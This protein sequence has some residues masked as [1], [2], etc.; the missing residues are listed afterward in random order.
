MTATAAFPFAAGATQPALDAALERP[1]FD[2][3]LRIGVMLDST[4]VPRWIEKVLRDIA[5]APHLDLSLVVVDASAAAPPR[6]S[7]TWREWLRRQRAAFPYR[8]WEWYL[9]ADYRRFKTEGEDPFATVDATPLLEGAAIDRVAP[10]RTKFVDRFRDEDV[11]RIKQAGLDVMLRFG[12]RI[13]KGGIL[14]VATF[15]VWSLHHDDNRAY[16]GGPALFWEMYERNP[17]SGSVLQVLTEAL[18]G[19]KVI[20]RSLGATNFASLHKNRREAYWKAAEFM[21]RRLTDLWREGW[22]YLESLETFDEPD[23]YARG[24]YR[25]PTNGV[26]VQFLAQTLVHRARMKALQQL[27]DRWVVAYRLRDRKS[28]PIT[29]VEPPRGRFYADPFLGEDRGR[30]FLFI[31]DFVEATG[32]GLISALEIRGDGTHGDVEPVLEREYHLSYPSIFR[33]KREWWM[34]PET[35][36]RRAVELYRAA[37]FPRGWTLERVLLDGVDARDATLVEW[38]GRWWM[39]VTICVAGGPRADELSLFY[40]DTPLGPWRPHP[41]NPIVSDV[42][43]ARSAGALYV[44]RG[45]LVRPAQ[46]CSRGYGYAVTLNRIDRVTER[47]YRETPIAA[48]PPTWH[49]RVRATHTV[50]RTP[51]VEAF[52]GR[53]LRWRLR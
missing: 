18:D 16:R 40:A 28:A 39:F 42:R 47:E 4:T 31:E 17:E 20:Y 27:D 43:R 33:W 32:R 24:I 38:N 2:R 25:R 22:S 6:R 46:N 14:G 10:V 36:D 1:A 12:F 23:T 29:I 37:D 3:P 11:A 50:A 52:D 53:L 45:A 19:G 35:G 13:I 9:D 34:V 7:E 5:T 21:P 41:R 49:P 26:M 48:L 15:G 44:E 30:T 51:S 8:A